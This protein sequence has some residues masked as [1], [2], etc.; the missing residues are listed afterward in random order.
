MLPAEASS[1]LTDLERR[2]RRLFWLSSVAMFLAIPAAW[3]LASGAGFR[4]TVIWTSWLSITI[5]HYLIVRAHRSFSKH[6]A[7]VF[8]RLATLVLAQPSL[9]HVLFFR[10][11]RISG[12]L[13]VVTGTSLGPEDPTS[14]Q[15]RV[16]EADFEEVAARLCQRIGLPLVK[17]GASANIRAAGAVKTSDSDWTIIATRLARSAQAVLLVPSDSP[18]VLDEIMIVIR[19]R[20]LEQTVFYLP[21]AKQYAD[22]G[23]DS[24]AARELLDQYRPNFPA[25]G[26]NGIF[27]SSPVGAATWRVDPGP[28]FD[29]R[30]LSRIL[31]S[32]LN[33]V[34]FTIV[35]WWFSIIVALIAWTVFPATAAA[36]GARNW[37]RRTSTFSPFI[38]RAVFLPIAVGIFWISGL[39]EFWVSERPGPM[40]RWLV[41]RTTPSNAR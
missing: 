35:P 11:F 7:A 18:G 34:R 25:P 36:L 30:Q 27:V 28:R 3:G 39:T 19:E 37:W 22:A 15:N 12:L 10:P 6:R 26:E 31:R 21:S 29:E 24:L 33:D 32:A 9:P 23:L 13:P 4:K 8:E 5:V 20:L 38:L 1:L 41:A 14:W 40:G 16:P 17:L 2:R